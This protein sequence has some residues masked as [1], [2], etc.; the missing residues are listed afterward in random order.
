MHE[1]LYS[2]KNSHIYKLLERSDKCRMSCGDNYETGL[3][4]AHS[5]FNLYI[6]IYIYIYVC[7]YI[8]IYIYIYIYIYL[9][10]MP[11]M[12]GKTWF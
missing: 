2:G 7:I 6:Y 3:S 10:V 12:N 1:H 4:R 11:A 5:S 9:F 8:F